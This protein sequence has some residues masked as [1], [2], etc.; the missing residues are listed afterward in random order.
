[1]PAPPSFLIF[2]LH[3]SYIKITAIPA[4]KS[5]MPQNIGSENHLRIKGMKAANMRAGE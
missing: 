2:L 4:I 5:I 1:M 3:L